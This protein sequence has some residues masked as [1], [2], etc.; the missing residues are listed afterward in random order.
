MSVSSEHF[1]ESD[2]TPGTGAIGALADYLD[3]D[4]EIAVRPQ[5]DQ[6]RDV[7]IDL[8]G[9]LTKSKDN[10]DYALR[11]SN[12]DVSALFAIEPDAVTEGSWVDPELD[13]QGD[14]AISMT[15]LGWSISIRRHVSR[16]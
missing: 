15:V 10:R 16:G 1:F 11:S 6:W 4:V 8:Y 9:R 5:G 14:D 13:E 7:R 2:S 12:G 3:K